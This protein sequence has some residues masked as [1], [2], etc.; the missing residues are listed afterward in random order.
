MTSSNDVHRPAPMSM[1][2]P[3]EFNPRS[4]TQIMPDQLLS[5]E[6]GRHLSC[7]SEE[8]SSRVIRRTFAFD[9]WDDDEKTMA[10]DRQK[11]G[12]FTLSESSFEKI[13]KKTRK[14][15]HGIFLDDDKTVKRSGTAKSF[16]DIEKWY[17]SNNASSNNEEGSTTSRYNTED[18]TNILMNPSSFS[19]TKKKLDIDDE[20]YTAVTPSPTTNTTYYPFPLYSY[21]SFG[22]ATLSSLDTTS[23]TLFLK[24]NLAFDLTQTNYASTPTIRSNSHQCES[25]PRRARADNNNCHGHDHDHDFTNTKGGSSAHLSSIQC[26]NRLFVSKNQESL[27]LNNNCFQR[28]ECSINTNILQEDDDNI[29]ESPTSNEISTSI[30]KYIMF[31]KKN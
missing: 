3:T 11:N 5:E 28:L 19:I 20:K 7:Y 13:E 25:I 12:E 15:F 1:W 27:S 22:R 6:E 30:P 4:T 9:E 14:S 23:V 2:S 24:E 31:Y 16:Q 17:K 21:Q 26:P 18:M 10:E 29:F 8:D